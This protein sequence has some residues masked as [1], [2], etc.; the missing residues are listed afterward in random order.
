METLELRLRCH[1]V[2]EPHNLSGNVQRLCKEKKFELESLELRNE[3]Y[4]IRLRRPR[5]SRA[6]TFFHGLFRHVLRTT[7][8]ISRTVA[9][10]S[11]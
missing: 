7:R 4:I 5:R 8:G 9:C 3:V 1:E 11:K 10:R 6:S 2:K